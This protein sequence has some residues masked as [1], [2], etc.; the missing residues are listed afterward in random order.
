MKYLVSYHF[1][2]KRRGATSML[3]V[4]VIFVFDVRQSVWFVL[5]NAIWE[6]LHYF[7]ETPLFSA[8]LFFAWKER[9]KERKSTSLFMHSGF[10]KC[11]LRSVAPGCYNSFLSSN[12]AFDR[13]TIEQFSHTCQE[14]RFWSTL[15]ANKDLYLIHINRSEKF[16]NLR[17][18][19]SADELRVAID[20]GRREAMAVHSDCW[21]FILSL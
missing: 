13:K 20:V 4:I 3:E 6:I 19:A 11:T 18:W 10:S 16:V 12:K 5:E 15:L 1:L 7:L 21:L 2:G 8:V 17:Q 9:M 14:D